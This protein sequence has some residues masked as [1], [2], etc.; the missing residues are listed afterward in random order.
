RESRRLLI[1][2]KLLHTV[3]PLQSLRTTKVD[4]FSEA[5]FSRAFSFKYPA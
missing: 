1:L 5:E 3:M 4:T 2:I